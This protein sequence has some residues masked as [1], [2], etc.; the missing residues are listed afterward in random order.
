MRYRK[1]DRYLLLLA[2]L[3]VLAILQRSDLPGEEVLPDIYR[4]VV[5]QPLLAGAAGALAEPELELTRLRSELE[6]SKFR[7]LQLK[8]QLSS[9]KEL[10]RFLRA[11]SWRTPP[12]AIPG[13]V[14]V[15]D[16]DPY[17]RMFQI[18]RGTSAGVAD[19]QAV[20][21]GKALL[22]RVVSVWQR[23]ATVRRVDDP[24]F[25]IEV[26]IALEHGYAR[27]IAVGSGD[28]GMDVRFL[29]GAGGI[30]P[31]ALVFT[32]AYD[33]FIPAGL[34]VGRIDEVEDENRDAVLEVS[35]TPAASLGRLSQ[36]EV[37][38]LKLE[39]HGR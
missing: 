19:G 10:G 37:L 32:S 23:G 14:I 18:D 8:Q 25:R 35:V 9:R 33:E 39:K 15:V 7:I 28:R 12:V 34:L 26:E 30:K 36:V 38:K 29:R 21:V 13:W 27:G 4:A 24:M 20:V 1:I 11:I 31:G 2:G 22:G 3:F 16:P 5:H 17:R 6:A